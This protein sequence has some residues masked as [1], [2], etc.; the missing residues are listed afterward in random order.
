MAVNSEYTSI[1]IISHRVACKRS[2]Y[3]CITY[4]SVKNT[5]RNFF[6]KKNLEKDVASGTRTTNLGISSLAHLPTEL[7]GLLLHFQSRLRAMVR[8]RSMGIFFLKSRHWRV[9][10]GERQFDQSPSMRRARFFQRYNAHLLKS[11]P[12]SLYNGTTNLSSFFYQFAT[13]PC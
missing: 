2:F 1:T 5:L 7:S 12:S 3:H 8:A 9:F 4:W 11:P 10:W 13:R 6:T